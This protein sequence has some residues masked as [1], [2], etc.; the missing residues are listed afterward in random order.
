LNAGSSQTL[1]GDLHA[2]RRGELHRRDRDD[3]DYV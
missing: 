2:D 1:V 3:D